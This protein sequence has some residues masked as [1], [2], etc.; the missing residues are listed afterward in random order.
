MTAL[1]F[2][3]VRNGPKRS[4]SELRTFWQSFTNTADTP[5]VVFSNPRFVG[6]PGEALRYFR[7]DAD[8]AETI[9][10]TYT[11]TGEVMAVHQLTKTFSLFR[12][13]L[14][15]KRAQLLTWD[16]AKQSDFIFIGSPQQNLP[17]GEV[18]WLKEFRFKPQTIEPRVGYVGIINERPRAGE[19]PLYFGSTSK[20]ARYDYG[21]VA[22]VP[23]VSPDRHALVLAGTTTLGTQGAAEFVCSREGIAELLRRMEV[24]NGTRMPLFE[25]IVHVRINGG[26]PVDTRL[27][28]VHVRPGRS[29]R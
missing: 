2:L 11:G 1:L 19:E 10:D 17:V 29:A 22:L 27:L 8:A 7:Q 23:G 12:K 26:V 14:R 18:Q 21:V 5:L 15:V 4:E 6:S 16:E 28:L 9:D 13:G 24:P 20:P 25:A 3:I